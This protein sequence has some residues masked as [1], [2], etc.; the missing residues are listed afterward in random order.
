MTADG[1]TV[2]RHG[3]PSYAS[4]KE[5]AAAANVTTPNA[6][7]RCQGLSKRQ[8]DGQPEWLTLLRRIANV[9]DQGTPAD[10]QLEA[11]SA[12]PVGPDPID[13]TA[14]Q[15]S[16]GH[17]QRELLGLDELVP[18]VDGIVFLGHT[19]ATILLA[20]SP[21]EKSR[22]QHPRKQIAIHVLQ[23]VGAYN[24]IELPIAHRKLLGFP[25]LVADAQA[26]RGNVVSGDL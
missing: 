8:L 11:A 18:V 3:V 12:E 10:R 25:A 14:N 26:A 23:T 16:P 13:R 24:G 15:P 7:V 4:R 19:E 9:R 17:H 21:V 20:K 5:C 2:W 6:R 1:V 22:D